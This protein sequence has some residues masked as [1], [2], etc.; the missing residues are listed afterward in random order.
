MATATG[1]LASMLRGMIGHELVFRE[2]EGKMIV[3]KAPGKRTTRPTRAMAVQNDKFRHGM[4]Y[5]VRMNQDADM[6]EAYYRK[7]APRQ[8][9][10]SRALQDYLTAPEV[11]D[12]NVNH[13][14]GQPGD[15]I[16]I[17]AHDDF[18]V[19]YVQVDI[20]SAGGVL[21][22]RGDA[23]VQP[24][25]LVWTYTARAE[26]R[27]LAGTKV[28]AYAMDIPNN[29]GT[30]SVTIEKTPETAKIA[31]PEESISP[32]EYQTMRSDTTCAH[33]DMYQVRR[34]TEMRALT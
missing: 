25:G 28:T 4:A 32:V 27:D 2:W 3:Q 15:T 16:E 20:W 6:K 29:E 1:L 23:V 19:A 33:C 5:G 8:N 21:V 13:Y 26:N 31:E 18:H 12:I 17:R 9:V 14:T 34:E 11:T 10:C 24:S 30:L 22:E 7:R